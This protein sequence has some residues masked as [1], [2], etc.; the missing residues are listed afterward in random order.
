MKKRLVSILLILALCLNTMLNGVWIVDAET[1]EGGMSTQ[2]GE[3]AEVTIDGSTKQYTDIKEAFTKAQKAERAT[4]KLLDNVTI[5]KDESG[6]SYGINLSG[7]DITLDLNGHTLQTTTEEK[8]FV[9]LNAV[10]YIEGDAAMTV[11]DSTGKGKIEQPNG[12]QAIKV[13]GGTLT[14]TSGTIEVTS[15]VENN[16]GDTIT[17]QN[18]AVFVSGSGTANIQGG[19]LIGNKG[20]YMNGGT[21]NVTGEPA[22]QGRNSYALLAEGGT[23][24]LSGGTYTSESDTHSIWNSQGT[25][26][27]LLTSGYRF[28]NGN[29]SKASLS[30]D[31][32]K[33]GVKGKAVVTFVRDE[34]SYV[35]GYLYSNNTFHTTSESTFTYINEAT[36]TLDEGFYV[37]KGN[38]NITGDVTAMSDKVKIILCDNA[39]LTIN[40]SLLMPRSGFEAGLKIYGQVGGT[41]RMSV[42]NDKG[43]ALKYNG[44]NPGRDTA[45]VFVYGG[46]LTITGAVTATDADV[47]M[48]ARDSNLMVKCTDLVTNKPIEYNDSVWLHIGENTR[49]CTFD[50][51]TEHEWKYSFDDESGANENKHLKLCSLC[52]FDGGSEA[53]SISKWTSNGASGHTGYCICGKKMETTDHDLKIIANADGRTH[54]QKCSKC[55]YATASGAHDFT[56]TETSL[57]G[58]T[59]TACKK[60][61]ALLAASYNNVPYASLQRAIDAAKDSG[62]TVTLQQ[63]VAECVTVAD[64]TVT[65]DLNNQ[66]WGGNLSDKKNNY[67]PL[68]VTGGKVTLQNGKLH[69]NGSTA[70]ARVGVVVNGGSL[71]VGENVSLRGGKS[72]RDIIYRSIDLQSGSLILSKGTALLTGLKVPS[73]KKLADYLP[74]GTAFVKCSYTTEDGLKIPDADQ[75]EYVTEAY[76]KN[77]STESM[78]VVAHKH[79]CTAENT[80]KCDCGFTCTH[81]TFADGRCTTCDYACPH[82]ASKV[83]EN[84]GVYTCKDCGTQMAVQVTK[85]GVTTYGTDLAAAMK[86]ATD[87]TTITLLAD[88]NIGNNTVHIYDENSTDHT[89]T[90]DLHGHN[91]TGGAGVSLG[92]GVYN[93]STASA[94]TGP[95]KLIIRGSGD[96]NL[97]IL[98]R[99]KGTLDLSG[100]TGNWIKYVS[101]ERGGTFNGTTGMGQID[102][103]HFGAWYPGGIGNVKLSSGSYGHFWMNSFQEDTEI[104]IGSLLEKDYAFQKTDGEKEFLNYKDKL[105]YQGHIYNVK[106]VKCPHSGDVIVTDDGS[107]RCAYCNTVVTAKISGDGKTAC[108]PML[109]DALNNATDGDTV[110][111]L[112]VATDAAIKHAITLDLNGFSIEKVTCSAERVKLQDSGENKGTIGTLTTSIGQLKDLL[113]EGYGFKKD[114]TWAD[115]SEL[116]GTTIDSV[117]VEQAPI[118]SLHLT[119]TNETATYGYDKANA[120]VIKATVTFSSESLGTE[121]VTYQWYQIEGGSV[122]RI[123]D[124]DAGIYPLNTGLDA[125]TYTFY[126]IATADGY[127][128]ASRNV[129]VTVEKAVAEGTAPQ[130]AENLSYTGSA[131]KL[132]TEGSTSDGV[133]KYSLVQ[134]GTYT[135]D[136]PAGTDTG[137]YTVWY[138][139]I[140][141]KNH[142]DSE[143]AS[144]K[145]TITP[146]K[147]SG[148][149]SPK[150]DGVNREYNKTDAAELTAVTFLKENGTDTIDVAAGDYTISNAHFND[151]NAGNDKQLIFTVTL[152]SHNY[153]FA[154]EDAEGLTEKTFKCAKDSNN[155]VYEITKAAVPTNLVNVDMMQKYTMTEGSVSV[156][157]VGMPQDAG[158]LSYAKKNDATISNVKDWEVDAKTGKVT[159]TLSGGAVNDSITLPVT[160]HSTNY[161]DATV[162]IVITL[163][164]KQVPVEKV[165]VAITG[166]NELVY[167]QKLSDLKL[168]TDT[169]KF[170]VDG[171][172]DEVVAGTLAWKDPDAIIDAGTTT[173]QWTF[174]PS[175]ENTYATLTGTV[176]IKVAKKEIK[177]NALDQG[178]I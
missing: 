22:I 122:N 102:M 153:V 12:G 49:S 65:I 19:T 109:A 158:T 118:E 75:Y 31:D 130:A 166:S 71:T 46:K 167:G 48:M 113:P 50:R 14:V 134:N 177:V 55:D 136:I 10:F 83:S 53:H 11:Q 4:V 165:K 69:Q 78:A 9:S 161:K 123:A 16:K 133:M 119:V 5:P 159:Y 138:K 163:T 86:N 120:P 174:T 162:S 148:V 107:Y 106:V 21:L 58:E 92:E 142:K 67:V 57:S 139:I 117:S 178:D 137:T 144:V 1:V 85:D 70:E 64:G 23:V 155:A 59:Y 160:I 151:V 2:S 143:P 105:G 97:I 95:G 20:I 41:G 87:D 80:Y 112:A 17:T 61:K 164:D 132:I 146:M 89:V 73:D 32:T 38:V 98:V 28:E 116:I 77:E 27:E 79:S 154:S 68:T 90:L 51:C 60:C 35:D 176:A 147:L 96:A 37:V 82:E 170:V 141:D 104:Q 26:E 66:K 128:V 110:T 171:T 103:V 157:Q 43:T 62:G 30:D 111:L 7:G 36:R 54:S 135:D 94:P 84:N 3:V 45:N 6:Y 108:Y 25:A 91:I 40:G 124:A 131:Q 76:T 8:G 24:Q 100:W 150:A 127:A 44:A 74:T 149:V 126:C 175:D 47:W 93:V 29:G 172:T 145:V 156:A 42:I 169:A 72:A 140:G 125:G 63:G 81:E 18:C 114:N 56:G 52:C 121:N 168:N 115:K 101:V 173:A 39:S 13:S 129:S 34:V 88:A 99:E 33:H 152:K 15:N